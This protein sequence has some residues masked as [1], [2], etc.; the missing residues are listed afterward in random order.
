ML[1]VVFP[2]EAL[3]LAAGIFAAKGALD[4]DALIAAVAL[5]AI[6]GDSIGYEIGRRWGRA[7][8]L[9]HGRRVGL[10]PERLDRVDTFFNRYGGVSVLIGRFIGYARA[11]VPLVAGSSRMPYGRFLACNVVGALCWS[12]AVVLLGFFVGTSWHIV[13]AWV[14]RTLLILTAV[15]ALLV[16]MHI[17]SPRWRLPLD[18]LVLVSAVCIFCAIAEDVMTQDPL[19]AFDIDIAQWFAD[20]RLAALTPVVLVITHLHDTISVTLASLAIGAV[21]LWKKAYR[22]LVTFAA[23]MA[24]GTLLNFG[25]KYIFRRDRPLPDDAV[26]T[27]SSFSFPSGH[28]IAATL[29]YGFAVAYVFA[30]SKRTGLRAAALAGASLA[31]LLVGF[32]RIYL[33]AHYLSDV[34]AAFAEGLAWLTLCL[35]LFQGRLSDWTWPRLQQLRQRVRGQ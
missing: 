9:S 25:L 2:G 6:V 10:T 3:V 26:V 22:W 13:Q 11:L 35:V 24:C 18:L 14:G 34:I 30:H 16:F 29:L 4:L 31:V 23:T 32:S 21:L 7:A 8:A 12:I 20:N 1:G 27:A 15:I 5:G 17:R 28:M 19:T 33:G